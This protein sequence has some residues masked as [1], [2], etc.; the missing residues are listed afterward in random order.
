[1]EMLALASSRLRDLSGEMVVPLEDTIGK[2]A[3]KLFP[4][5]QQR[6][7]SLAGRLQALGLPGDDR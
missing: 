4:D 5:L 7:A 1:M 2:G 3:T 6:Y